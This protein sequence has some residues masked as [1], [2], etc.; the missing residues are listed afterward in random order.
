LTKGKIVGETKRVTRKPTSGKKKQRQGSHEIESSRK[1]SAH[2][3]AL[4]TQGEDEPKHI[5]GKNTSIFAQR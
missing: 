1:P 3:E 2:K 5:K 4:F